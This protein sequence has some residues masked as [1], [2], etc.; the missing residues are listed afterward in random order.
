MKTGVTKRIVFFQKRYINRDDKERYMLRFTIFECLYF[1]IKFH[2]FFASDD[3]CLHDHPWS[4]LSFILWR[5]YNEITPRN[6]KFYENELK[7][8]QFGG[9]WYNVSRYYPGH[10]IFRP[11][12]SIHRVELIKDKQ[13]RELPAYTFVISFKR[14]RKWGFFTKA[15]WLHWKAYNQKEHC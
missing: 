7:T 6:K 3:Q 10:V 5:G 15:G 12:K 14:V 11:A 4:F 1:S 9:A 13:G 2:K 8:S